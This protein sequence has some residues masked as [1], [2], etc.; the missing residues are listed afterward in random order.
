MVNIVDAMFGRTSKDVCNSRVGNL[1]VVGDT[2]TTNCK[3]SAK[4]IA[5]FT[6]QGRVGC[7]LRASPSLYDDECPGTAKYLEVNYTCVSPGTNSVRSFKGVLK[8]VIMK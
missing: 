8:M 6:C 3:A 7:I 1:A 2:T 5:A 4:E